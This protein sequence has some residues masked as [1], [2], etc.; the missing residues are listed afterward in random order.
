AW[1]DDDVDISVHALIG[2][3]GSGKTRLALEFCAA[4]DSDPAGKGEWIAGFVSPTDLSRFVDTLATHS[5]AWERQTLVVIDN[6]AQCGTALERWLDRVVSQ[7][8]DIKLR[9]LLLDREAPEAFGWW[10]DLTKE[11]TQ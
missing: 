10:H 4:I 7:K 3:A 5:F 8:L 11:Q 9:I 6:A 1:L 2:P